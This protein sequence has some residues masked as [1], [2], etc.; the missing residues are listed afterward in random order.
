M[1]LTATAIGAFPKPDYV[2]LPDWFA[3][4]GASNPTVGWSEALAKMGDEAQGIIKRG[5]GEAVCAQVA[6]GVD[7]PTDGEI[8]R[9]NT[10]IITAAILWAWT[11]KSA[12]KKKRA[13]ATIVRFCR[14]CAGLFRRVSFF[15]P[16]IGGVLNRPLTSR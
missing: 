3:D 2:K 5:V 8:A 6:A 7:I 14:P 16:M 12:L 1:P 13:S 9:E 4:M 15:L 11:L 10:S